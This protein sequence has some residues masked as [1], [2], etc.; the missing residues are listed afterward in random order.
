[1]NTG[2]K[3][4]STSPAH[5]R[6]GSKKTAKQIPKVPPALQFKP[7]VDWK[8]VAWNTIFFTIEYINTLQLG[9]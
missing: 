2:D 3:H 6:V 9:F 1:V 5:C 7:L 4:I 8:F